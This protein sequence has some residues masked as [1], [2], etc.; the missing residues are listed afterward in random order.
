[1]HQPATAVMTAGAGAASPV[2]TML[3][4]WLNMPDGMLPIWQSKRCC[5]VFIMVRA[6]LFNRLVLH[7]TVAPVRKFPEQLSL[8]RN[9]RRAILSQQV[10]EP[11][12]RFGRV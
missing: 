8:C 7:R 10:M 3:V 9:E 4:A 6:L 2:A 12:F 5:V 1:M 11:D